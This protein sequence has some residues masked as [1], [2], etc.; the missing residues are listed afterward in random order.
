MDNK[1]EPIEIEETNT[2]VE[3][4]IFLTPLEAD[5]QTIFNYITQNKLQNGKHSIG[6]IVFDYSFFPF[7]NVIYNKRQYIL[8]KQSRIIKFYTKFQKKLIYKESHFI[9]S[10]E[11]FKQ[12]LE[13][14][15]VYKFI[16]ITENSNLDDSNTSVDDYKSAFSDTNINNILIYSV[17]NILT[18]ENL[19]KK[20][21][22]DIAF[23]NFKIKELSLNSQKYFPETVENIFIKSKII[24]NYLSDLSTFANLKDN[25]ILYLLGVKG[26]S[27]TTLLLIFVQT[28][29][30]L[31]QNQNIGCMYFNINYMKNLSLTETKKVLLKEALYLISNPTELN[32]FKSCHPFKNNIKIQEPIYTVKLFIEDIISNYDKIFMNSKLIIFIIDNFYINNEKESICLKDIIKFFQISKLNI[33]LIISGSGKFFNK[34]IRNHFLNKDIKR[35]SVIYM[36]NSDFGFPII[37][38]EEIQNAPLYYFLY[39]PE[40]ELYSNFKERMIIKEKEYLKNY[41]FQILYYSFDINKLTITLEQLETFDIYDSLPDYFN[42]VCKDNNIKFEINNQIFLEAIQETIQ[43]MVQNNLYK[44]II[45]EKQLPETSCGYAEEFLIT[46]LLRYNKIKVKNLND[47]KYVEKVQEIYNFNKNSLINFNKDYSG[48]ILITQKYNGRNYDLLAIVTINGVDYA[49]FIQIGVDKTEIQIQTIKDELTK[50]YKNYIYNLNKTYNKDITYINL[51]FI[52]DDKKQQPLMNKAGDKSCGSKICEAMNIDYLWYST[53]NN[54]LFFIKY[55]PKL[56]N[57]KIPLTEYIPG[58]FLLSSENKNS[59]KNGKINVDF[60]L[61]P[62]YQLTKEQESKINNIIGKEYE[63]SSILGKNFQIMFPKESIIN[64]VSII[65]ET[66]TPYVHIFSTE[67]NKGIYIYYN[68]KTFKINKN[69]KIFDD[70]DFGNYNFVTWDI[71][72]LRKKNNN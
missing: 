25:I 19:S 7:D 70:S 51:L 54:D 65:S 24:S 36:N 32:K 50:N 68:G 20:L 30:N 69:P 39:N 3:D 9:Y 55:V 53:E 62:I 10:P 15:N 44:N 61:R 4:D 47:F 1:S 41:N 23:S 26:C 22:K 42:I 37:H 60:E 52:F 57:K 13:K 59:I 17:S 49:I 63:F 64:Y 38:Y 31:D 45:I 56:Y 35:E 11:Y 12:I 21:I 14:L 2:I 46:L 66:E 67:Q 48:N 5:L 6:K 43:F 18:E 71:Y 16:V 8:F 28:L 33:K 40:K 58:K 72:K 29:L 27:K 34:K